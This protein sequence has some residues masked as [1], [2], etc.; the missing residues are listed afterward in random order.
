ME[1]VM[2]CIQCKAS[3]TLQAGE[4]IGFRA[5]CDSCDA[6][7]HSCLQC[8]HHDTTAYNE[9]REPMAE[10]VQTR[11]RGNYCDYFSPSLSDSA[12]SGEKTEQE[13]AK[14]DL[15]ALFRKS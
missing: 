4:K 13:K 7:L 14:Q 12:A 1:G 9:C 11:D 3:I 10:R 6:D 5:T 8:T 15:A 2:R